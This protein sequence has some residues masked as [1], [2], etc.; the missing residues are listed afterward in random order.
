MRN[1]ASD[2]DEATPEVG[3]PGSFIAGCAIGLAVLVGVGALVALRAAGKERERRRETDRRLEEIAVR[4]RGRPAPRADGSGADWTGQG[5]LGLAA[6]AVDGWGNPLRY[7]APG[8]VH[9]AGWDLWSCGPNGKDD[10]G[11]WDDVLVSGD[12]IASPA[13]RP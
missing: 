1:G 10:E 9:R 5:A 13:S 6:P 3:R 2:P 8:P 4:V 11:T 12:G 7:R